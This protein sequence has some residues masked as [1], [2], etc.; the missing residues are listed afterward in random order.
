MRS[1]SKQGQPKEDLYICQ[2]GSKRRTA[3]ELTDTLDLIRLKI[4]YFVHL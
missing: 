2:Y 3:E 1:A 4:V